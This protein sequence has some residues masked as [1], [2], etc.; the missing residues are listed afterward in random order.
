MRPTVGTSL[1]RLAGGLD[2]RR[3]PRGPGSVVLVLDGP[4]DL[5]TAPALAEHVDREL[6]RCSRLELDVA[7]V[8]FCG[9]PGVRALTRV[10]TAAEALGVDLVVSGASPM[11]R[12]V[13][14]ICGRDD[15]VVWIEEGAGG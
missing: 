6:V 15:A 10:G 8:T 5:V 1:V 11:L 2:V 14:V 9:A 13:M 4:L 12:R 3:V 7:G